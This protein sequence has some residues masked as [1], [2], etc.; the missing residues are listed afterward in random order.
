MEEI[1]FDQAFTFK[2]SPR[3]GTAA[4]RMTGQVAEEAKQAASSGW[5]KW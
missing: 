4:E 3:R 1:R 2:F 5:R